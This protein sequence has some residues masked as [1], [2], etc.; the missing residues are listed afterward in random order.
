MQNFIWRRQL[1]NPTIKPDFVKSVFKMSI[2]KASGRRLAPETLLEAVA[3]PHLR[4]NGCV[5][6]QIEILTYSRVRSKT[7]VPIRGKPCP[8]AESEILKQLL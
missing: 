4:P 6:P 8:W 3:K 2:Q 5:I 7:R 1:D